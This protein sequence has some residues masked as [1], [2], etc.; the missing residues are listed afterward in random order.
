MFI[1][2]A[3]TCDKL[4]CRRGLCI[5]DFLCLQS[6]LSGLI[7]IHRMHIRVSIGAD[8]E[9]YVPDDFVLLTRTGTSRLFQVLKMS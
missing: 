1:E 5:L 7:L 4:H 9:L 8:I 6:S 3:V 2:S